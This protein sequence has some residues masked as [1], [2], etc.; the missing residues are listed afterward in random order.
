MTFEMNL[1]KVPFGLIKSGQKVI[2]MRLNTPKRAS[3]KPGDYIE[4]T[5]NDDG[6]KLKVLVL[7]ITK[8]ASFIELYRHFDKALLGYQKNE[9]ANPDDM[10]IYYKKE[11]IEKYGVIAIEIKVI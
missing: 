6:S 10:L 9:K 2:E 4:F 5:N 7:N 8:F 11:D 3:I 1:A